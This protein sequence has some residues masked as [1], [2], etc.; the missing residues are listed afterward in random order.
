MPVKFIVGDLDMSY[1][2][3]GVKEFVHGSGFK[4]HVPLLEDVVVI[5]GTGHFINQERPRKSI[6]TSTTS[7]RSSD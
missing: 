4:K 7:S 1:T 3:P 6:L 2:T 5:E